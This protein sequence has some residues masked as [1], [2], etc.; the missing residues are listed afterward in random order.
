MRNKGR[1][2]L[3][4]LEAALLFHDRI[5][6]LP[7]TPDDRKMSAFLEKSG[8]RVLPGGESAI[9]GR[10]DEMFPTGGTNEDDPVFAVA[11]DG[12]EALAREHAGL[13]EC[14]A[15][16]LD[17]ENGTLRDMT[18]P[19][20]LARL[21][22][23][24]LT[25]EP[26][27]LDRGLFYSLS[28]DMSGKEL[29]AL[30]Q[31]VGQRARRF[32]E[33]LMTDHTERGV[34]IPP[35]TDEW[36]ITERF[37]EK[38]LDHWFRPW[39]RL[40]GAIEYDIDAHM[41][42]LGGGEILDERS[43]SSILLGYSR[44]EEYKP[45][46]EREFKGFVSNK[47][48]DYG[49]DYSKMSPELRTPDLLKKWETDYPY[50]MESK[51]WDLLSMAYRAGVRRT[52]T[53]KEK[54]DLGNGFIGGETLFNRY[55]PIVLGPTLP[56]GKVTGL[57]QIDY[58]DCTNAFVVLDGDRKAVFFDGLSKQQKHSVLERVFDTLKYSKKIRLGNRQAAGP[59]L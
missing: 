57:G 37:I 27:T 15:W 17:T 44:L 59:K 4:M 21:L 52:V 55:L 3:T 5:D 10:L 42:R 16:C 1:E 34:D 33:G 12:F 22:V 26:F 45:Y 43:L 50:L 40:A 9:E 56:E 54:P 25:E 58:K 20:E 35:P 51:E 19:L 41:T 48:L 8:I 29:A 31:V 6:G 14:S 32:Y 28:R 36:Q 7:V 13:Y 46:L 11:K 49:L 18:A 2:R 38:E 23:D 47:C 24:E 30:R 53:L 39:T